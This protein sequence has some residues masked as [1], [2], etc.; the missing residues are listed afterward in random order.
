MG[1][2]FR[3]PARCEKMSQLPLARAAYATVLPSGDSVGDVSSPADSVIRANEL[4]RASGGPAG[5][6]SSHDPTAATT[7]SAA[8][9]HASHAPGA[10]AGA[11]AT[12]VAAG[13]DVD[14]VES[15]SSAKARSFAD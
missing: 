4:H 7:A 14:G 1:V 15:V 9:V 6:F 3:P 11:G 13:D 8:T 12:P 10:R 2:A 5:L